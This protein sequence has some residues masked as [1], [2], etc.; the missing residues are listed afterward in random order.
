MVILLGGKGYIGSAFALELE[1]RQICYKVISRST[2]DYTSFEC[3]CRLLDIYQPSFL[4]NAAG[5]V[6]MPNVDACEKA[7]SEAIL[8][9]VILPQIIS[10][11]CG[12]RGIPWAHVSS[13]CIFSGA[14]ILSDGTSRV[15]KDLTLPHLRKIVEESPSSVIGYNEDDVPNF[16]FRDAPC[17]FYSGSKALAEE[18]ISKAKQTYIWRLRIP[19]DEYDNDRNYL[20]K[21][22]RYERVY[23]NVNSIS[24]RQDFVTACLDLWQSNAS[25]GTYNVTNPGFVTSRQVIEMIQSNSKVR[26]AFCFWKDDEEFYRIA[27]TAPRSNCVLDTSKLL[28]AGVKMR[29]VVH[30]LEESIMRWTSI[31][32]HHLQ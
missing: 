4:I 14:K 5:S 6:G 18:V 29:P 24:H 10:A 12:L 19:F 26:R 30:A 1:R 20:S 9:N 3:L 16:S 25:F 13:G 21:L 11:A 17:S 31:P 28:A 22:Q 32:R 7:R 27:A 15:E 8:G 2:F 23:D